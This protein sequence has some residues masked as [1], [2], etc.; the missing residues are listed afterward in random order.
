VR[1]DHWDYGD[2]D[3]AYVTPFFARE[4]SLTSEWHDWVAGKS[5]AIT[6]WLG[7]P[8]QLP[9]SPVTKSALWSIYP[10]SGIAFCEHAAWQLRWD[11]SPLG[12][13]KTAAHGHLDALHLSLWQN[14]VAM[15]IDPGTG[16]YYAD[17][18]LRNWLAS[19]AAHNGPCPVGEEWPKRLGPFLWKEHHPVPTWQQRAASKDL[20]AAMLAELVLAQEKIQRAVTLLPDGRGISVADGLLPGADSVTEFTVRWQFAP[21]SS[22]KRL[23]EREFVLTRSGQSLH[24][25]LDP[26]WERV[27]LVEQR[28]G[29][30]LE[31][32]VSQRFRETQWAPYLKLYGRGTGD[33]PCV[34][35]TRFLASPRS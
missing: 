29:D 14:G 34:F 22:V 10:Q 27:E 15:V 25:Q 35:S 7:Q 21:G 23:S 30:S 5:P 28:A 4:S 33:K 3:S 11:L 31:G 2:S 32:I 6:Y 24:I 19:R 8:P 16:C 20:P 17:K 26:A 13:L 1:A 9:P 18:K 12:Y